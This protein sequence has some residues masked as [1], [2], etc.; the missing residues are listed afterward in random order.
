[1]KLIFVRHGEPDYEHDTL[2]DR[3]RKEAK[4]LIPRAADW[5]KQEIFVSPLGRA[6]LT[7][8][9]ALELPET[10]ETPYPTLDWLR[11]FD[12]RINRPDAPDKESIAWDWL[13]GDWMREEA[14]F[15][16]ASWNLSPV[17]AQSDAKEKYEHVCSE[18]DLLLAAH[19]YARDGGERDVPLYLVEKESRA[20]LVFFCHFGL[21]CV[22]LS[23]LTGVSPMVLWHGFCAAPASVTEVLTEERKKGIASW[24]VSTFGDT[25]H[26]YAA[27]LVPSA[28]ARFTDIYSDMSLRHD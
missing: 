4:A 20:V 12:A 15:Q 24:R 25:S 19:G 3:G 5:K 27:G 10:G 14:H 13:P 1:M 23:H 2:T 21:T 9:I 18:L 11:E 22:A 17:F 6:Q 26:L 28:H 8:R 16:R 7:A